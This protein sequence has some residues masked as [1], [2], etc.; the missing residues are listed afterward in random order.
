[1]AHLA[2]AAVALDEG[3]VR[4]AVDHA[5]AASQQANRVGARLVLGLSHSLAG[6]ALAALGDPEQGVAELERA[7]SV[8]EE[9]GARRRVAA[10]KRD[11]RQL[12]RPLHNRS[13]PAKPGGNGV[14]SL[15][16]RELEIARLVVDRRTN[17]EIAG[18]LFLSVKTVETHMRNIF[19][20]LDASSRV[21]VARIIERGQAGRGRAP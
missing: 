3:D 20:K 12:G 9:C 4:V 6:R 15:T 1:M 8:L 11:L 21:D 16:G 2:T 10:V 5:L 19:R 18:E 14:A 7:L 17:P 13:P